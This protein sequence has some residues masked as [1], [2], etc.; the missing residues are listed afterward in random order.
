M[1]HQ[2]MTS[3]SALAAAKAI[4]QQKKLR[5]TDKR[6]QVF[7]VLA[8]QHTALGA[9]EI[10]D[11]LRDSKQMSMP[12]MSIYRILD[13]LVDNH[14]AHRLSSINKFLICQHLCCEHEHKLAQFLICNECQSIEEITAS[15]HSQQDIEAITSHSGFQLSNRQVELNGTC[16]QCQHQ[17]N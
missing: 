1:K 7:S 17:T 5:F 6:P 2:L 12:M 10:A 11:I 8:S 14:L 9:S 4:C 15:E 16:K 3:E 13:F